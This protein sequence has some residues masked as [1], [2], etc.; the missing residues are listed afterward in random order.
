VIVLVGAACV[1]GAFGVAARSSTLD[2]HHPDQGK[3][4]ASIPEPL[5]RVV[6]FRGAITVVD[7]GEPDGRSGWSAG[8]HAGADRDALTAG[9]AQAPVCTP[10]R[11]M[12][13]RPPTGRGT[14]GESRRASGVALGPVL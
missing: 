3:N 1:K 4:A 7:R 14:G 6:T 9:P 11:I 10:G 8:V 2:P 13:G 5:T 12:I